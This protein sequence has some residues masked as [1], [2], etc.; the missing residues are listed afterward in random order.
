MP[1]VYVW[2]WIK[3]VIISRCSFEQSIVKVDHS[4]CQKSEPLSPYP[5]SKSTLRITTLIDKFYIEGRQPEVIRLVSQVFK[6][7]FKDPLFLS[8]ENTSSLKLVVVVVDL[9][10][11]L[12]HF[13]FKEDSL[14]LKAQIF[15]SIKYP[16]DWLIIDLCSNIVKILDWLSNDFSVLL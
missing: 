4:F 13:F 9:L 15:S 2:F 3:K 5:I 12:I 16:C 10:L 1:W 8:G 11:L 14:N 6:G 7:W